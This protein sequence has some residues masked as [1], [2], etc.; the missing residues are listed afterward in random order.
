MFKINQI[1]T[2]KFYADSLMNDL[3]EFA[4]KKREEINERWAKNLSTRRKDSKEIAL[5]KR[6]D[7]E[8][9][10]IRYI[11]DRL[12]R[13]V[14]SL[15]KQFPNFLKID[16]IYIKLIDTSNAP[17]HEIKDALSKLKWIGD[18]CDEFTQVFEGKI[19]R[20]KTHETL[21]FLMKKYLGKVNSLFRKN[22]HVFITLE[23]ARR[24]MNKLPTFKDMYTIA[25]GG[26][27]NV[28]KSTLM[29]N[30]TGSNVEIQ[31]YPFTTKGLMFSYLQHNNKDLIQLIDTP[32]LLG[33]NKN[34]S[35]EQRAELILRE[36]AKQIVFVLDLTESCGY[37]LEEQLKLLKQTAK[38]SKNIVIYFSKTDLFGELEEERKEEISQHIKKFKQFNDIEELKQFLITSTLQDLKQFNIKTIKK[39]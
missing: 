27:P 31:N 13:L 7:L 38:T 8:L 32:G 35:I 11:N 29:K 22:K 19:K 37:S 16:D 30:M 26:F 1:E 4:L 33:R 24:F 6:K 17:V 15:S 20:A 3:S 36:Y 34:N 18:Y 5:N 2:S 14:R 39:I 9:E 10:K 25:I 21:G 23:T 28:G 12:N